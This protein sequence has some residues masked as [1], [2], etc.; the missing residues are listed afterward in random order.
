METMA[1]SG[2]ALYASIDLLTAIHIGCGRRGAILGYLRGYVITILSS[3]FV[4]RLGVCDI[5]L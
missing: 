1:E 4:S 3:A 2:P 5:I